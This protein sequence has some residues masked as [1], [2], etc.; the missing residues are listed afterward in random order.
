MRV[1]KILLLLASTIVLLTA[2]GAGG[3]GGGGGGDDSGGGNSGTT[4]TEAT[5]TVTDSSI[6]GD[7]NVAIRSYSNGELEGAPG[8]FSTNNSGL[9]ILL[10]NFAHPLV[11]ASPEVND[12]WTITAS[13][14]NVPL[15]INATVQSLSATV[16]TQAGTFGNCLQIVYNYNYGSNPGNGLQFPQQI[17]RYFVENV[18]LVK[19]IITKATQT[20]TAELIS[21]SISGNFLALSNNWT[22]QWDVYWWWYD[23]LTETFTVTAIQNSN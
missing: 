5:L 17:V 23:G 9:S 18:G 10:Y 1:L 15:T 12:S 22:Y 14:D 4:W 6:N 11:P 19:A 20:E 7:G 16:T 3:G 2:C 13:L 21:Y 8:T